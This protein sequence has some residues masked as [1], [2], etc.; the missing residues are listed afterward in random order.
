MLAL[1]LVAQSGPLFLYQGQEIGMINAPQHWD[2]EAEYKDVQSQNYWAEAVRLDDDA[3]DRGRKER[4][5]RG[6]QLMARDHARLPFQWDASANGGF[7]TGK[8]WMRVHDS[9]PENN[10]E[11]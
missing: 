8:L 5:K 6:L 11:A 2:V 7:S 1:W 4:I 10:A 3:T 9:Y